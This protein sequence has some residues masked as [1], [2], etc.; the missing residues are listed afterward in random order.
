MNIFVLALIAFLVQI[1][2]NIIVLVKIVPLISKVK[3]NKVVE[4]KQLFD[5]ANKLDLNTILNSMVNK[6]EHI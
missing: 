5:A 3:K 4:A 6:D 2:T 1:V